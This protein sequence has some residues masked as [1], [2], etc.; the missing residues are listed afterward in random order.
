[1]PKALIGL[2]LG[3][4]ACK[5]ALVDLRL[6]LLMSA[7]QP[8][9]LI[10]L[11]AEKIEQDANRWWEAAKGVIQRLVSESAINPADVLAVS[12]SA[13]GLSFVPVDRQGDPIRNA[14]NWLDTR[15]TRQRAEILEEFDEKTLFAITGKRASAAYVLPKLLWLKQEEPEIYSRCYKILMAMD[16]IIAKLCGRF[17]T[18]HTMAGGT[19]YYDIHQRNWSKPILERFDLDRGKLPEIEWSGAA[20]GTLR[21]KVAEELGLTNQLI[22]YVGGQ[23]QKVAALGAGID[24]DRTTISLGTAVAITQKCTQPVIDEQMR[25]P[26]FTDLLNGRWVLE[27]SGIGT[28]SLDW[29]RTTFFAHLSYEELNAMVFAE[30]GKRNGVFLYPF[31]TGPDT[32]HP[33]QGIQGFLY[34]LN[35]SVTNNQIVKSVFEGVAYQI[36]ENISV[37][38][39]IS[40]PVQELR[41][42][43]GGSKSDVWNQVIADVTAKP[44]VSLFTSEAGCLGAAILAGLGVGTYSY[45]DQAFAYIRIQKVYEPRAAIVAQYAEQYQ[46]YL[47]I[48][49][50]M[51]M[52]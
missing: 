47:R 1:M 48:Q 30:H 39:E 13:Q 26:C 50:R 41:V 33:V 27:G 5:G 11:S 22:V 28:S 43:G 9:P 38:E 12:I 46:D 20:A 31:F 25:I 23:D 34:G 10:T 36:C 45:A 8:Y 40:K 32:L 3:T 52:I 2:D 42:F 49:R 6:N 16:F 4:T 29:L 35:F 14:F 18:D 21:K 19:L 51:T 24:L 15:A 37:I 7:E 44:V 17:I